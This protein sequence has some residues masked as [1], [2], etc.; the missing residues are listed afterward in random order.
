MRVSS[1]TELY[2]RY[3]LGDRSLETVKN[4]VLTELGARGDGSAIIVH[5]RYQN[6]DNPALGTLA[7][8]LCTSTYF[9]ILT[10]PRRST[11]TPSGPPRSPT[12]CA[13]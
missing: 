3:R 4:S 5:D 11:P 8:Q 6:Y 1:R 7:H 10:E 12:R 9:V 2:T 13:D